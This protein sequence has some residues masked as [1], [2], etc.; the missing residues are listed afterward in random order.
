VDDWDGWDDPA[1]LRIRLDVA[2]EHIAELT[3]KNRRLRE[4]L[5]MPAPD[6]VPERPEAVERPA[7]TPTR[8]PT[9]RPGE[10]PQ[11]THRA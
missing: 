6:T 11:S 1:E 2:L 8:P 5:G 3:E 10:V 4:R 7:G 9:P